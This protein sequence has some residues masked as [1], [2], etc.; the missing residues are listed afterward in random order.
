MEI[1]MTASK[2]RIIPCNLRLFLYSLLL[3]VYSANAAVYTLG[4]SLSDAGSLGFTYTNP[5]S[6][7]PLISGKVWVQNLTESTP[8]FCNSQKSCLLNSQTY[9]YTNPGNN[10]AVGGAG[11]TFNST[12]ADVK[13]NYTNLHS[14]IYAL[15]HGRKLHTDDSVTVWMGAN[16]ILAAAK[17]P[18][19]S[20]AV[21]INAAAV[22]YNEVSNLT[23][24]NL[25]TKFYVITIPDLGTTPFGIISAESIL[26]SELT[27]IFNNI[28]ISGLKIMPNVYLINSDILFN[29]LSQT[30]NSST[31][32]CS[33][34]V[35]PSHICGDLKTNPINPYPGSIPLLFAD[36]IHPSDATHRYI[37]NLP[38]LKSIH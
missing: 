19:T 12:D 37:S 32:Y 24:F 14:Q 35:D 22:F 36:P 9:Y 23:K 28:G 25:G 30:F 16:D 27:A 34:I 33:V 4:D 21:V 29:Q 17:H 6:V 20:R 1:I 13:Q 15:T 3:V 26:L 10:F 11:V 31:L 2:I 38:E 8:A 5:S 7:T 18:A